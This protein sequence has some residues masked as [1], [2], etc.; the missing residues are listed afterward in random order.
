MLS[1]C[2]IHPSWIFWDSSPYIHH[3]ITYKAMANRCS[4]PIATNVKLLENLTDLEN[5]RR[6]GDSEMWL[7]H[8]YNDDEGI[9]TTFFDSRQ[10][11]YPFGDVIVFIIISTYTWQLKM[12]PCLFTLCATA[13]AISDMFCLP[14]SIYHMLKNTLLILMNPHEE[15]QKEMTLV[16][17][18]GAM[19]SSSSLETNS[20]C[21]NSFG[22]TAVLQVPN[23]RSDSIDRHWPINIPDRLYMFCKL[24]FYRHK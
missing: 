20:G 4:I 12:I 19:Y 16:D 1:A 18:L 22:N 15:W 14:W 6:S 10:Y 2:V 24:S 17:Q 9:M 13:D 21:I 3:M 7:Y 23:K 8:Q 5:M 11:V